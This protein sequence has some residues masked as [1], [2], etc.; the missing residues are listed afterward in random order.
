LSVSPKKPE[1]L[2]DLANLFTLIL[3]FIIVGFNREGDIAKGKCR[4]LPSHNP[5]WLILAIM[6]RTAFDSHKIT[7]D[8]LGKIYK[9]RKVKDKLLDF[10]EILT[11]QPNSRMHR[12]MVSGGKKAGMVLKHDDVFMKSAWRWYQCRVVYSSIED[13]CNKQ[14]EVVLLDPKNIYKEIRPFDEAVGYGKHSKSK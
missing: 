11:K 7:L 4:V 12:W 8:R 6:Y 10:E 14:A 1:H 9:V 13:F 3:E 5:P 2:D